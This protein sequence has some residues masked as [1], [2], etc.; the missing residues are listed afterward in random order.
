MLR[1]VWHR[2]KADA[3]LRKH[4]VSFDEAA[5]VFGDP[6]SIT[7]PDPGHSLGEARWLLLGQSAPGRLLVVAHVER[8]DEIRIIS[9]RAASR[10]ERETYEE[11]Q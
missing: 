4:G 11:D 2:G 6:L 5:T 9:A 10:R 3:N 1:F 8:A 7:I